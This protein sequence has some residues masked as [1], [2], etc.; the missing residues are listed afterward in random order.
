MSSFLRYLAGSAIVLMLTLAFMQHIAVM[1]VMRWQNSRADRLIL[2]GYVI[3]SKRLRWYHKI[4]GLRSIDF[5]PTYVPE[6]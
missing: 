4:V 1:V 3:K 6:D 5:A 2:I